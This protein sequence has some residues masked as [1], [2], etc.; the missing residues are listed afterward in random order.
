[1][2]DAPLRIL[3]CTDSAGAGARL[4]AAIRRAYG[5]HASITTPTTDAMRMAIRELVERARA[6]R[7]GAARTDHPSIFDGPDIMFVTHDL[8]HISASSG[9]DLAYLA[10]CHASPAV[11]VVLDATGP[12]FELH[13]PSVPTPFTDLRIASTHLENPGLWSDDFTGF[14]PWRWPVLPREARAAR[15]RF[16]LALR[17]LDSPVFATIGM[18]DDAF[19]DGLSTPAIMAISPRTNPSWKDVT[20]RELALTTEIGI[21]GRIIPSD[22]GLAWIAA[23]RLA[24]WLR[25]FV[26]PAHAPL[27]DAAHL[28]ELFPSLMDYSEDLERWNQAAALDFHLGALGLDADHLERMKLDVHP[29][30]DRPV[31]LTSA[32]KTQTSFPEVADPW[33]QPPRAVVF[34]EDLSRFIPEGAA[35]RFTADTAHGSGSVIDLATPAG[36]AVVS[37]E[38]ARAHEA[39]VSWPACDPATPQRVPAHALDDHCCGWCYAVAVERD[40]LNWACVQHRPL[41]YSVDRVERGRA[42]ALGLRLRV[43]PVAAVL[44][45]HGLAE[46]A[47]R[48]RSFR[49]HATDHEAAPSQPSLRHMATFLIAH[50]DIGRPGIFVTPNGLMQLEWRDPEA[51]L[52]AIEFSPDGAAHF[53]AVSDTDLTRSLE[54]K[55]TPAYALSMV[56][57]FV[58]FAA[59]PATP[60][61]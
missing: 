50:R 17:H 53:V 38:Q 25:D 30:L 4:H 40:D 49:Q 15:E 46:A 3:V 36:R 41:L 13:N 29:W 48:V 51:G 16:D 44:D 2:P 37:D 11:I 24:H 8:I 61:E 19:L 55:G 33:D 20:F 58:A 32:I 35:R 57:A 42:A 5:D 45:E 47:Q 9:D 39:D 12:Q 56:E 59:D 27:I 28:A 34:A 31:W 21:R 7:D 1:M 26:V 54:G 6:R 22:H 14:R 23:A 52:C 43:M 60:S 18:T 10:R